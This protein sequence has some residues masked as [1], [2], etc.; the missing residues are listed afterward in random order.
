MASSEKKILEG[1]ISK[2]A[3]VQTLCRTGNDPCKSIVDTICAA[4]KASV[5]TKLKFQQWIALGENIENRLRRDSKHSLL[6]QCMEAHKFYFQ[7]ATAVESLCYKLAEAGDTLSTSEKLYQELN[8]KVVATLMADCTTE[9]TDT[10][11]MLVS[12]SSRKLDAAFESVASIGGSGCRSH[13]MT[14]VK[15]QIFWNQLRQLQPTPL[16][17]A[18]ADLEK[19]T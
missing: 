1:I 7:E 15:T 5:V 6:K 4:V 19:E 9:L 12:Q 14:L 8:H 18:I 10:V 17:A 3:V 16:K 11:K 13:G 2:I